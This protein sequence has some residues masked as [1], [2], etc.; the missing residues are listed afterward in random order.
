MIE[1]LVVIAI[2]TIGVVYTSST[3]EAESNV[4]ADKSA[5]DA[6]DEAEG[7]S[8]IGILGIDVVARK[9]RRVVG[10]REGAVSADTIAEYRASEDDDFDPYEDL[11]DDDYAMAEDTVEAEDD[12]A[13]DWDEEAELA[14]AMEEDWGDDLVLDRV[15][16]AARAPDLPMEASDDIRSEEI[17]DDAPEHQPVSRDLSR[18]TPPAA[19]RA[20]GALD[21]DTS[22]APIVDEFD[23]NHDQILIGYRP[24]EAGNGRIGIIEDPLRPGCAAVTL[25]GRCVAV[26]LG[27][28][29]KVRAH[30]IDLVCEEDDVAA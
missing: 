7:Q 14:A 3:G 29:G 24:G 6:L 30:H 19:P 23:P 22:D 20:A 18:A 2:A 26:V 9:M 5:K 21:I 8:G 10:L 11:A 15:A 25:G 12:W 28:F 16:E 4:M 1:L 13:D 27:G 17:A